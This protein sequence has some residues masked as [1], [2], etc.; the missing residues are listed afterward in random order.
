M[1]VTIARNGDLSASND[2]RI[3]TVTLPL[4]A[5][6]SADPEWSFETSVSAQINVG[7]ADWEAQLRGALAAEVDDALTDAQRAWAYHA[8]LANTLTAEVDAYLGN[9]EV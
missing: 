3:V 8:Y 7:Q 5:T 4:I 6:N 1:P 2:A 9:L